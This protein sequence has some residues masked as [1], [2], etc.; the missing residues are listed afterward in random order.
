MAKKS[1]KE[2]EVTQVVE[3]IKEG[4][5]EAVSPDAGEKKEKAETKP[6]KAKSA[7]KKKKEEVSKAE[8]AAEEKQEVPEKAEKPV[9]AP[10]E[11]KAAEEPKKPGKKAIVHIYSS[12]N[13]TII[14]VTD[15]TGAE[16]V[17]RVSG[18]MVTKQDRLKGAPFQAMLAAGKAI[19]ATEAQGFTEIDILVRAPGGHKELDVGKGAEQAIKAFTKSRLSIGVVEDVTPI[20]HGRMKRKGGRRGR[21]L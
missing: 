14:H 6:K 19:E 13:N 3:E 8:E 12:G 16:T 9:E 11:A 20:I 4:T 1:A 10:K 17:S 18:G 15:V 2:A 5:V 21:R 7:P